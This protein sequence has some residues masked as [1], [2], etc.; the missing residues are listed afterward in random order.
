LIETK[1]SKQTPLYLKI[2][3]RYPPTNYLISRDRKRRHDSTELLNDIIIIWWNWSLKRNTATKED[4]DF[5]IGNVQL[6]KII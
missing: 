1:L 3:N 5:S 6:H 2:E 4:R